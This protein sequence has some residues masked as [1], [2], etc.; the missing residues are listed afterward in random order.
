M[1]RCEL[2]FIWVEEGMVVSRHSAT[3]IFMNMDISFCN[4]KHVNVKLNLLL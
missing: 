1:C 2:Y 3:K 4:N